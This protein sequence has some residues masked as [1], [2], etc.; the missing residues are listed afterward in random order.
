MQCIVH[1]CDNHFPWD[2][3]YQLSQSFSTTAFQ[4]AWHEWVELAHYRIDS[5]SWMQRKAKSKGSEVVVPDAVD[6]LS[7]V[8]SLLSVS[9]FSVLPA[10]SSSSSGLKVF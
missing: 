4:I 9:S 3:I 8:L 10:S 2:S 1:L 7:S 5:E 6:L